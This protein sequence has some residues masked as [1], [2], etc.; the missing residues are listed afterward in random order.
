VTG[1]GGGAGGTDKRIVRP[2]SA[3]TQRLALKTGATIPQI[4]LGY[5]NR[6]KVRRPATR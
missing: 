6:R 1:N 2:M 5:G 4:G 3:I